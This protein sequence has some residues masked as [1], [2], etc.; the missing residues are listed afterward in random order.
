M[1]KMWYTVESRYVKLD[2][3]ESS[4]IAK[5]SEAPLKSSAFQLNLPLLSKISIV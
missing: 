5:L 3:L 1:H 4:F 2:L